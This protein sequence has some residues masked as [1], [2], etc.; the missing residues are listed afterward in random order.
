MAA[1][2]RGQIVY[3]DRDRKHPHVVVHVEGTYVT[4]VPLNTR[5]HGTHQGN[6]HNAA[7]EREWY[8]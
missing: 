1:P 6:L 2:H 7:G 4:S 3:L 8:A 5:I